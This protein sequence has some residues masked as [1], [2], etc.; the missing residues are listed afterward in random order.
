MDK[1]NFSANRQ[2]K[3]DKP[4]YE[5]AAPKACLFCSKNLVPTF[6]D[7]VTLKKFMSSRAKIV[8]KQRSGICAKHQR[9]LTREIKR[10]RHLAL[11]PFT[12]SV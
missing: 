1:Q 3:L 7:S 2:G 5:K 8:P 4:R 12:S 6:T 9:V 11:L 10:A